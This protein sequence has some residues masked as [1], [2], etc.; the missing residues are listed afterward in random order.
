[1]DWCNDPK[2][3]LNRQGVA[4]RPHEK[5]EK[6][7][8]TDPCDDPRCALN[9]EGIRHNANEHAHAGVGSATADD[10]EPEPR[11]TDGTRP[12]RKTRPFDWLAEDPDKT[13]NKPGRRYRDMYG[14]DRTPFDDALEELDRRFNRDYGYKNPGDGSN[15][16]GSS[17]SKSGSEKVGGKDGG[18]NLGREKTAGTRREVA[19][20]PT[21]EEARI[22]GSD[23][24]HTVLGLPAGAG[25]AEI[26]ERYKALVRKYDP[27]RGIITKSA[28]KKAREE[29][30]M[31][32]VHRAYGRLKGRGP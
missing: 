7:A 21:D 1:M 31:V 24:P 20:N 29:Q 4:H 32:K 11:S 14:D 18:W 10:T 13:E 6:E 30:L 22:L 17:G 28:E 23:D 27:S 25:P 16:A 19:E 9:R 26:R 15:R 3:G 8:L 2:C 12:K 5:I